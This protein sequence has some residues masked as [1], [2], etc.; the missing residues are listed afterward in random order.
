MTAHLQL[1]NVL[2]QQGNLRAAIQ[3]FQTALKLDP[4]NASVHR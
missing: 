1:G 2:R 4:N 3:S